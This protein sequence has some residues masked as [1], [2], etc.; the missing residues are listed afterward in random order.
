M[1]EEDGMDDW[2]AAMAEQAD[3]EAEE[4]E[5]EES[6]DLGA[7][8]IDVQVAELDELQEDKPITPEEK[9][10]LEEINAKTIFKG[11]VLLKG[12]ALKIA[13]ALSLESGIIPDEIRAELEKS[14][15]QVQT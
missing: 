3:A 1:S 12:T 13:Q 10:K 7:N 15:N 2:A 9:K 6:P 8:E 14:Y 11:L 4:G 5:A